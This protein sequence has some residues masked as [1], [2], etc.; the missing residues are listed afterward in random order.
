MTQQQTRECPECGGTGSVI[1]MPHNYVTRRKAVCLTC[2][3]TG[4]DPDERRARD[5][6]EREWR[7]IP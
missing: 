1:F 4:F 6:R 5:E 2:D 3:G 7:S